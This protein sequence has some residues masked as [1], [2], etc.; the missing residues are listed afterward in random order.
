MSGGLAGSNL[1]RLRPLSLADVDAMMTWV[2]DPDVVGNLAV[3]AGQPITR[4]DEVAYVERMMASRE[5]RVFAIE[6]ASDGAYLGNVGLHQI[7]WRSRVGRVACIIGARSE[8]GRGYGSA[9]IRA[10]L[11]FAF[12]PA[13]GAGGVEGLGLHKVWLVVFATNQRSIGIYRRLGFS[14]EGRLREEYFHGG[15]W[16][17]MV[18]MSVL[19]AEWRSL[20]R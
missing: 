20:R 15:G 5:D 6:R 12:A 13:A 14:E 4:A 16:H 10:A 11:D 2:N 3:F 8:M 19:A 17:D 18:R 9:A 1:V 7:H